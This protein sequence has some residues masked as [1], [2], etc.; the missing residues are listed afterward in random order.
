MTVKLIR[1]LKKL[2][3]TQKKNDVPFMEKY[4]I[5]KISLFLA[6]WS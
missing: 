2:A 4:C 1:A 3:A 5:Q 6:S